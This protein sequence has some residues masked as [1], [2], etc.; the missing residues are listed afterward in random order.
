MERDQ[1]GPEHFAAWLDWAKEWRLGLD[2]NPSYFSHP[3]AA[4]GF[5]LSSRDESKRQFWVA[6]GIAC[7]KIGAAFG[8]RLGTPCVT[9]FWIPDGYKRY[10]H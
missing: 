2:F 8:K 6:H 1:L 3:L 4:D 10:A 7:R 9:N 5:T